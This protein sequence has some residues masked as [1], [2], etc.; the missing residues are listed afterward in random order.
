M[1]PATMLNQD[2]KTRYAAKGS[3]ITHAGYE[4]GVHALTGE[5]KD[6]LDSYL[7]SRYSPA[8]ILAQLSQEFPK[9]SLPSR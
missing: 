8:K 7:R 6:K 2:N 9:I 5:V 4:T 1:F 3:S